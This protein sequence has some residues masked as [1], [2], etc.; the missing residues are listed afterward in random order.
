[1]KETKTAY[2]VCKAC[3]SQAV[4]DESN[5]CPV[6]GKMLIEDY[7]PL[8]RLRSSYRLQGKSFLV[9]NAPQEEIKDLF[10]INKNPASETAWACFV[11][12]L[13]P[14]LGILFIPI[15]LII[16][17]FA[18]LVSAKNPALG[19]RKLSLASFGLSFPVLAF[20]ILLWWLLYIIPELAKRI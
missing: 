2:S 13:V 19:G 12:S 4:R 17:S 20:Q 18:V 6:C 16:S 3:G 10:E 1:M 11:Y 14:Y 8:D 5:Y 9:E 15:T 7:Q